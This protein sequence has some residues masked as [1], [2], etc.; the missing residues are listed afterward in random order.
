MQRRQVLA[1]LV[2]GSVAATGRT[3]ADD[4]RTTA[5]RSATTRSGEIDPLAFDSTC[6]LLDANRDP[7]TGEAEY[8]VATAERTAFN[9]DANGDDTND[10]PT[11][12]GA[13]EFVPYPDDASIP[14]VAS[15]GGVIGIG[16][17]FLQDGTSFQSAGNEEFVLNVLDAETAETDDTQTVVWD[18]GHGQFF[19]TERHRAFTGYA[20][21][22]G[23]SVVG[24]QDL[25]SELASDP[26]AAVVTT[27]PESF[28]AAELDAVANFVARGGVLLLFSQSDFGGFNQPANLN[29]ICAAVDAPFRFNDDQ[30]TDFVNNG[31]I[32]FVPTTDAFDRSFPYFTDRPG[33]APPTFERGRRYTVEVIEVADGDTVDIQFQ[34]GFIDEVR[35]LGIDTPETFLPAELVAEWEGI[36]DADFLA[37]RG[38]IASQFAFDQLFGEEV[39]VFFDSEEPFRGGFGRLLMFLEYDADGDGE[40]DTNYNRRVI[41]EGYGRVFDSG[42]SRHDAFVALER[43][44]KARG[45]GVWSESDVDAT[46]ALADRPARLDRIFVP[47]AVPVAGVASDAGDAG[48]GSSGNGRG[49]SVEVVARASET[50]TEPNAPLAAL[51]RE[52]GVALVGGQVIDEDYDEPDTQVEDPASYDD[53]QFAAALAETLT[54]RAGEFLIDG[55]RGQ[56]AEEEA[57]G[58]EDA[59]FFGRYLEGLDTTLTQYNTLETGE[60]SNGRA[61]FVSNPAESF[62]DDELAA[63]NRF[64]QGGGAVVVL[65]DRTGDRE[66]VDEFL[67]ALDTPLRVGRGVVDDPEA[68]AG[69]PFLPVAD[70]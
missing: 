37:R 9:E 31:G 43:R 5:A 32:F 3:T 48:G 58:A 26:A 28:T 45:V 35:L 24:T 64:R 6:S 68:N 70:G 1:A 2:A 23:Y 25:A 54:Q 7:V 51:D 67:A 20:E 40:I 39:E 62:S 14:L 50:A 29:E 38:E 60:L 19:T 41:E 34:N 8:V 27:P 33:L 44:A 15:A 57:V 49:A 66:R 22:N 53:F 59:A 17:V 12:D 16:A 47:K 11:D 4:G 65:A 63:V 42:F 10:D 55:G 52:A 21:N 36:D 61:L 18:E 46:P 30:V 13:S 69:E 56:F